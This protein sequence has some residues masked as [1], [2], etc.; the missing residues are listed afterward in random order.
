[1][2]AD[3]ARVAAARRLLARLRVSVADLQDNTQ[4]ACMP[5]VAEYLPQV[6][7]GT[8]PGARRTYGSYWARMADVWGARR[9]DEIAA[10]DIEALQR[11]TVAAARWRPTSRGGGTPGSM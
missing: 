9:L 4:L 3:P 10:S 8:G 7:A 6:L 11:E 2:V 1:M 5:T